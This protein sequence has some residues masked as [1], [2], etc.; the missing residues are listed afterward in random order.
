MLELVINGGEMWDPVREEFVNTSTTTLKLEHSLVSISK[1]EA[2]YKRAFLSEKEGPKNDEEVIDYIRFM[3][4]NEVPDPSI[5]NSMSRDTVEIVLKYME[6]SQTATTFNEANSRRRGRRNIKRITAEII[7]WEMITLGIPLECEN[8]NF[9]RL[10]TLIRVCDEKE[11][12]TKK[13]SQN[14]ILRQYASVNAK[15]RRH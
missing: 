10:M 13:M 15:R 7:Y 4:L 9:N 5:Y 8:W 12:P 1:W 11:T 14:D 3:T 6:D 2:K